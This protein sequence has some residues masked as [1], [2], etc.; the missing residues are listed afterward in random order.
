M[1]SALIRRAIFL[2]WFTIGYN[3]IEGAVSIAFGV[4]EESVAL[5]G[6][7]VDSLIEVASASL[8]LWR[9][10]SEAHVGSEISIGR[11]RKAT[12]GI[13]I[14]FLLLA[15]ITLAASVFQLKAGSHPTT[16]L[17]GLVISAASLSFM[18][19]LWASKR[20]VAAQLN[21][22]SIMKDAACSLACIKLSVVLFAGSLVFWTFPALWWADS[23]AALLLGILIGKEGWETVGAARHPEFSGGCGCSH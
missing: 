14:L 19:W 18:F 5:A 22:A 23:V 10:R 12:L 3:L 16:T 4:G 20:R 9:F 11:E 21:S 17:P 7:G 1:N 15:A 13:G 6:F 2:S 8:I